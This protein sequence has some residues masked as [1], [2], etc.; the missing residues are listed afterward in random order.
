M[1]GGHRGMVSRV[2][3]PV[4]SAAV[5]RCLLGSVASAADTAPRQLLR[6]RFRRVLARPR[7]WVWRAACLRMLR[8]AL[9]DLA[10][11]SCRLVAAPLPGGPRHR[12]T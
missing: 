7:R 4:D 1:R 8:K 6:A 12:G 5:R 9:T 10:R 3:I 2:A 11:T